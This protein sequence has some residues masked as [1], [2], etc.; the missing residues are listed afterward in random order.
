MTNDGISISPFTPSQ[1]VDYDFFV[2]RKENINRIEHRIKY[3]IQ[4]NQVQIVFIRGKQGIGKTSLAKYCN[5][6][7]RAEYMMQGFHILLAG[8][9]GPKS[10]N[11]F[12]KIVF[13][14]IKHQARKAGLTNKITDFLSDIIDEVSV[15]IN[16]INIKSSNNKEKLENLSLVS[17]ID[18]LEK[19]YEKLNNEI[20]RTGLLLVLDEIDGVAEC[21]YFANFIKCLSDYVNVNKINLPILILICG[22]SSK[23]ASITNNLERTADYM[24]PIDI[25]KLSDIDVGSFFRISFEKL[26]LPIRQK[27]LDRIVAFADGSP[28]LMHLIGDEIYLRARSNVHIDDNIACV[29]ISEAAKTWGNKYAPLR[30]REIIEDEYYHKVI[31]AIDDLDI[32]MKLV[33]SEIEKKIGRKY[34]KSIKD[35]II[36]LNKLELLKRSDDKGIWVFTNRLISLYLQVCLKK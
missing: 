1:P 29:G 32:E 22:T 14:Q 11:D 30:L 20:D 34:L 15:K 35:F 31:L 23:Y 21:P 6:Y 26:M 18:F 28:R 7:M 27:A 33:E 17:F 19:F 4:A 13:D 36:S 3:C 8:N 25:S 9:D 5:I 2:G 12:Y 10:I 16:N 24:D